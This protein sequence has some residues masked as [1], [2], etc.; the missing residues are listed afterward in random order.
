MYVNTFFLYYYHRG[1]PHAQRIKAWFHNHTRGPASGSGSRGLLKLKQ[2]KPRVGQEWQVYQQ[3]T[4]E[5]QWKVEIDKEWDALTKEWE[6]KNPGQPM[7]TSRFNFMNT[8]LQAK[9]KE[10]SEEVKDEVKKRRAAMKEEGG[11]GNNDME[12]DAKNEAFQ[13]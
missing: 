7:I 3:M 2:G 1:S 5:T 12:A 4:Y 11:G 13:K 10:E 6:A 9:Y 8:F